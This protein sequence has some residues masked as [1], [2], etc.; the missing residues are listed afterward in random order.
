MEVPPP[1]GEGASAEQRAAAIKQIDADAQRLKTPVV[2]RHDA[3]G[4]VSKK[5]TQI[6][7]PL[8]DATQIAIDS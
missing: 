5:L 1:G 3:H 7:I 2:A 4:I 6:G 8:D